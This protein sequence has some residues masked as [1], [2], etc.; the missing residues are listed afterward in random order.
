MTEKDIYNKDACAMKHNYINWYFSLIVGLQLMCFSSFGWLAVK[1]ISLESRVSSIDAGV[2]A[3]LDSID[4][5]MIQ[6][7][8]KLERVDSKIDTLMERLPKK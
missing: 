7:W 1:V 4:R 2:S 5:Q 8:S 6:V 3:R